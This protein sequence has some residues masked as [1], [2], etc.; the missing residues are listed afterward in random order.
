MRRQL[1]HPHKISGTS[2]E[3]P[4]PSNNSLNVLIINLKSILTKSYIK[5]CVYCHGFVLSRGW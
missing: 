5:Y 2:I 4:F 1:E 3:F